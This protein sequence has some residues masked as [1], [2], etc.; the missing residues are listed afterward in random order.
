MNLKSSR[1]YTAFKDKPWAWIILALSCGV[2]A[3]SFYG[4]QQSVSDENGKT[5][6]HQVIVGL[7]SSLNHSPKPKPVLEAQAVISKLK[8]DTSEDITQTLKRFS[9]VND[10]WVLAQIGSSVSEDVLYN[11]EENLKKQVKDV[12]Q[13]L[14]LKSKNFPK[15]GAFFTY[16]QAFS[17]PQKMPCITI[18][19]TEMGVNTDQMADLMESLPAAI[20]LA[21]LPSAPNLGAQIQENRQ[22]G[23]EILLM[24]PLEPIYYPQNDPGENLLL[25]GLSPDENKQRLQGHLKESQG[26][27]GVVGLMGSRFLSSP[28]DVAP[29]LKELQGKG[30]VMVEAP[31]SARSVTETLAFGVDVPFLSF[32]TQ[33]DETLDQEALEAQLKF[34]EEEAVKTGSARGYGA[35][36]PLTLKVLI[37]W[38]E[39]LAQK[40]ILLAPISG[41][42]AL[43]GIGVTP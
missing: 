20:T 16:R 15:E 43:K 30:L 40:G 41:D 18:L 42:S 21:F 39:T 34:L 9:L 23:H 36:Y 17:N 31:F 26:I 25:T 3:L 8:A 27:I 28:L 22:R 10:T 19:L 2:L 11:F 6:K 14:R 7:P 32:S 13:P 12:F 1:F 4:W 38:A 35:A 33:I 37:K 24:L 29:F 5:G